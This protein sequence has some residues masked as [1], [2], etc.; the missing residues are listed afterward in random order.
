[1][2]APPNPSTSPTATDF[3]ASQLVE[4][5]LRH[6]GL[7]QGEVR[8]GVEQTLA[9]LVGC[10]GGQQA[11]LVGLESNPSNVEILAEHHPDRPLSFAQWVAGLDID[12][13]HRLRAELGVD[14]CQ[15]YEA[16][17]LAGSCPT[18]CRFGW[19]RC[20]VCPV[21][22]TPY[23]AVLI[24]GRFDRTLA[25]LPSRAS[26]EQVALLLGPMI[27]RLDCD[28]V[29]AQR[30][31]NSDRMALVGRAVV[32]MAHDF[33][34]VL[35]TISCVSDVLLLEQSESAQTRSDIEE[36][37]KA[38]TRGAALTRQ[39]VNFAKPQILECAVVD[40]G[41]LIARFESVIKRI[42]GEQFR[43]E[44]ALPNPP[45]RV[46]TIPPLIEQLLLELAIDA[47]V[48]NPLGG[49]FSI[50]IAKD[51]PGTNAPSPT[52]LET[53]PPSAQ[54]VVSVFGTGPRR[55]EI[56]ALLETLRGRGLLLGVELDSSATIRLLLPHVLEAVAPGSGDN[57]RGAPQLQGD[58]TATLLL[59][60]DEGA[61]RAATLRMLVRN[62]YH[63][64]DAC[65]VRDALSVA[66][67]FTG[68]IDLVMTDVLLPDGDG[69]SLHATL[70]E[71]RPNV[72][73]LFL[74]GYGREVLSRYHLKAEQYRFLAKP[75]RMTRLLDTVH[76]MLTE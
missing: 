21:S 4:L 42:L 60:E 37:K 72:R 20:A 25:T 24:V 9:L 75:F 55:P 30:L 34:N 16:E 53:R 29:V 54:L 33:N 50:A 19:L 48:Q 11:V 68:T 38:A 51:P 39:L 45:L 49:R 6:S 70:G 69:V 1:M 67:Q 57:S 58:S 52:T 61:A 56:T 3:T 41:E 65:S 73:V 74:S 18:L 32:G 76:E 28:R 62:G 43:L 14:A 12:S 15:T 17:E 36:I 26:V 64:L 22:N 27:R 23:R 46:R 13:G 47:H 8:V 66:K 44:L 10:G 40:F 35:Y 2:A 5:T 31:V 59:V 71:S 7:C 63:V